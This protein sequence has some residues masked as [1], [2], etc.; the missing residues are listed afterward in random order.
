MSQKGFGHRVHA[1]LAEEPGQQFVQGKWRFWF[2]VVVGFTLINAGLTAVVFSNAGPLQNA[3]VTILAGV[4]GLVA[5]LCIG[6]LHYSDSS[7]R[8]LARGVSALDSV[9][10][11]FVVAHFSFLLWTYGHLKT[12]QSAE[13][14]YE[15]AAATYNAK[16]EKISEDNAK[17][18]ASAE[19]IEAER[20]KRA[21]IENDTVYQ[22]RKAAQAGAKVHTPRSAGGAAP[23]LSTAPIELEKPVKAAESSVAFLTRWD[24]WIRILNF[25]ELALA[26][27][28]LIFIRNRS[29]STNDPRQVSAGGIP[30]PIGV[31]TRSPALAAAFDRDASRARQI[32]SPDLGEASQDY[33]EASQDGLRELQEICSE[34]S[35]RHPGRW[36]AVDLRGDH[37]RVRLRAR[38]DGREVTIK[39]ARLT[40]EVL[41]DVLTM[42]REAFTARFERLLKKLGFEI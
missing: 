21:R 33:G 40:L 5:W 13:A 42:E 28:T 30:A 19:R 41:Q 8:T 7:D 11:V 23:S 39:T 10:L 26:V 4:G 9:V 20:T 18:F 6:A 25:G 37:V 27:V 29:A 3:M 12:L 32:A 34:I 35:F 31:T 15:T 14:K 36:Y 38:R 17:M 2:P 1:W 22:A 16:A 24:A